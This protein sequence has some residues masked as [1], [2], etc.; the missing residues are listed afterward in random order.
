M[1]S[2]ITIREGSDIISEYPQ[3]APHVSPTSKYMHMNSVARFNDV[4]VENS[5]QYLSKVQA[6][7]S[8]NAIDAVIENSL[9][10]IFPGGQ[11]CT[12]YNIKDTTW[13]STSRFDHPYFVTIEGLNDVLV[14]SRIDED[15][16]VKLINLQTVQ[17]KR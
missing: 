17:R 11:K 6:L 13:K 5:K 4:A 12:M 3:A 8:Y 7:I 15:A 14:N 10:V 9:L 16:K 1:D 2:D